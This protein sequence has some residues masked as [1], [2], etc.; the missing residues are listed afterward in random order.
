MSEVAYISTVSSYNVA[1]IFSRMVFD[2]LAQEQNTDMYWVLHNSNS[3]EVDKESRQGWI[4]F[5]AFQVLKEAGLLA[6]PLLIRGVNELDVCRGRYLD[7]IKEVINLVYD[8]RHDDYR[9]AFHT[10]GSIPSRP[11]QLRARFAFLKQDWGKYLSLQPITSRHRFRR[12]SY[13]GLRPLIERA[14]LD[15]IGKVVCLGNVEDKRNILGYINRIERDFQV[16]VED[17]CGRGIRDCLT[18]L[19]NADR[20]VG[21]EDY[22]PLFAS[23]V[24]VPSTLFHQTD[25]GHLGHYKRMWAENSFL[26]S[27]VNNFNT[28]LDWSD[29]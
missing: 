10:F 17:R 9:F 21:C 15:G 2:L 7:E 29:F 8:R 22:S 6:R 28:A 20:H 3:C 14:V 19:Y 18:V 12:I 5:E 4:H 24:G 11:E 26:R 1:E 16:Q 13:Q 23:Q 27:E 25:L